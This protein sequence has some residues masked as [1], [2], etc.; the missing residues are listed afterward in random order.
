[1][2]DVLH[3]EE[4]GDPI[5][6]ELFDYLGQPV[7]IREHARLSTTAWSI[8]DEV[9]G[10]EVLTSWTGVDSPEPM[11]VVSRSFS[12]NMW[13]PNNPPLIYK[14][15]VFDADYRLIDSSRYATQSE[16][17]QGHQELINKYKETE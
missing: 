8:R 4:T 15:L 2:H 1:M 10:V 17:A 14:S 7:S 5:T 6:V 9:D 3:D 12:Y 11:E 16:A 13:E